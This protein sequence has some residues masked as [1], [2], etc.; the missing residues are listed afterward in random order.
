MASA[1][2]LFA[3]VGCGASDGLNRQAVSGQVL[4]GSEPLNG[5][6]EFSPVA[7][8]GIA[9]GAMITNGEYTIPAE[10]GLPPGDYLVRITAAGDEKTPATM[11]DEAEE[12]P[13]EII[14]VAKEK[15]PAAYNSESKEIRTV[16]A[17]KLNQFDFAIP[18]SK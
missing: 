12:A 11:N 2:F 7:T 13:G 15:V 9:S 16:E 6:I 5:T 1:L 8:T 14:L 17:D 4:L 18:T 3:I 10:A